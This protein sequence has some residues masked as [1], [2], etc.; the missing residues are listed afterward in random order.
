MAS[1]KNFENRV[2]RWL[3]SI[4]IYPLATPIQKKPVPAIG[5]W[6]KR[7]GGGIYQKKGLPDMQIV[8]KGRC[9]EVELKGEG[10]HPSEIQKKVI[11]EINESGGVGIVIY[12]DE[13]E[14]LKEM[15]RGI[16]D[17]N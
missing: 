1:E 14:I 10:G 12:P 13:F 17:G 6:V 4:G 8:V 9:I 5:Y 11:K 16:I 7:W 3:C 2:K 15:I